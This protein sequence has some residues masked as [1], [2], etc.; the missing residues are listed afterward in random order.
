MKQQ[1]VMRASDELDKRTSG[2]SQTV[3]V[4]HIESH[5]L[6]QERQIPTEPQGHLRSIRE[7]PKSRTRVHDLLHLESN[8][9]Q[10]MAIL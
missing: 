10:Y 1:R 4:W 3:R 7:I 6:L 9:S 5:N 8:V 2:I